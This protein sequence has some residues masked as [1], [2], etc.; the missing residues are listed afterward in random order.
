[1]KEKDFS[2]AYSNIF[3]VVLSL[4]LMYFHLIVG[5]ISLAVGGLIIKQQLE[6]EK[7]QQQEMDSYMETFTMTMDFKTK[8]SIT[9]FY[10]PLVMSNNKGI[11]VWYNKSFSDLIGKKG[12]FGERLEDYIPEFN[13]DE[14]IEKEEGD[15]LIDRYADKILKAVYYVNQ[16]KERKDRNL[17]ISFEDITEFENIKQAKE[18]QKPSLISIQIDSLDEVISSTEEQK[19]PRL[20]AEIEKRLKEWAEEN[21]IALRR[22]SSDKFLAIATEEDL[23]EMEE[24]KFKVLDDIRAI[25][26]ENTIPVSLSMGVASFTN[27]LRETQQ[28]AESALDIA[29]GRGGDQVAVR[30]EDKY[31]FYGGSSKAIEKKT[32]VKARIVSYALKDLVLESSDVLVMGH[33][34]ADLDAVGS[35]LGVVAIANMLHKEAKIVLEESNSSIDMLYQRIIQDPQ[36][37]KVFISKQEAKNR[38][39]PTTLLVVV[40]T[41]KPSL[42]EYPDLVKMSEKTVIIDHHRRSEE[43][44]DSPVLVYHETYVSSTSEMVTE[45][46]QYIQDK[47][48][49]NPTVSEALLAGIQLDTKNFTFKTGVRTFE[50]AAF[51]RKYGADTVA[52]KTLFQGDM[53]NY[54]DQLDAMR[55]TKIID[56][57]IAMTHLDK[58]TQNPQLIASK[59]ADELLNLK[60]IQASFVLAEDTKGEIQVSAR[61]LGKINVQVIMEKLGGGGH[62]ETAAT[63]LRNTSMEAAIEEVENQISNYIKETTSK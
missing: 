56:D 28:I 16:G 22:T 1:M 32:R 5:F 31:N 59:V 23:R 41:H 13:I 42:T 43:F 52:V 35:A 40:D 11:I 62:M 2:T 36:Y 27:S 17:M 7:K 14:M 63:Q 45:L 38:I 55:K 15:L 21:Q 29:L 4:I 57:M 47:P 25:D 48:Q 54:I 50:A 18:D 60:G 19:R 37:A 24:N 26:Y 20:T 12:L 10:I 33:N 34:Y 3:M 46:I 51:L 9:N 30:R 8:Q 61:S 6:A 39:S 58:C 49:V 44:V 53:D